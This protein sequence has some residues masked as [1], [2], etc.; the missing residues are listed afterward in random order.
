MMKNH[1]EQ[2]TRVLGVCLM[3]ST[4]LLQVPI[5]V[6]GSIQQQNDVVAF[7]NVHV[8][9][10]D[11]ER[12]LENQT[13]IVEGD[14]ITAVGPVDEVAVPAD[15]QIVAAEGHYLIPGLADMHWHFSD[16]PDSLTLAVA[17]GITTI[18]NLNSDLQDLAWAADVA[19]GERVGPRVV[20]G[21]HAA[22]LPPD[23]QFVLEWVNQSAAPLFSLNDYIT[24]LG[25]RYRA[26]F[27]FQY[28]AQ[29]GRQFVLQAKAAGGDFIKTN[30][31]LTRETFDAIVATAQ[32]QDMK[33]QGHVW[34]D[35]GVEHYIQSGAQI[36]HTTEVAPYLSQNAIQGIPAQ[37]WDF[38]ALEENLP[39]LVALMKDHD[40]AFTPTVDIGWYLRQHYE[41]FDSL[42]Q[43]PQIRYVPPQTLREWR[44]LEQNLVYANFGRD[45]SNL[46]VIDRLDD[47]QAQL[48]PALAEAGVTLLAGTD[49]T[50]IPGM[51]WGYTLHQEIAM[52][53]DFGLTPYQALETATRNPA[54]FLE[55]LDEWGTIEAGKRADLV[56][57]RASPLDDIAN[58]RQIAGI[59]LRGDWYPQEKL[60]Q[61][62][63]EL[64]EKYEAQAEGVIELEPFTVEGLSG[65]VP[66][67]WNELEAGIYTRSNPELDP[68]LIAQMAAP[69]E[70]AES[71]ALAVLANFGLTELPATPM[72]SY[73]SAALT[74]EIYLLESERATLGLA[75][76]ETDQVAYL[77]LLAAAP[78]EIDTLAETLFFPVVD[79][80]MPAEK[81]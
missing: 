21:P 3:L 17:N 23:I 36:H 37:K 25:S 59:M 69:G 51:V 58:T 64:A 70:D 11:T 54:K 32:E 42:L 57:L 68:T 52:L 5:A 16:N 24:A 18:Q 76:A 10:M 19:A 38:L 41:D 27:G 26:P 73:E 79:A 63:D 15:A 80:L 56:L 81:K 35:I 44:N 55:E 28:D 48:I 75:L 46:A 47:F 34:G 67:G 6:A 40:M 12:I 8:I 60:Q 45:T 29:T 7:V 71:I 1:I 53:A 66:A 9:P 2:I 43:M 78:D 13:V 33:V 49:C 72:D 4:L 30:L 22:G 77:V 39:K 62:L 31:F 20:S 50:A 65:V 14:R 74:W 61:M